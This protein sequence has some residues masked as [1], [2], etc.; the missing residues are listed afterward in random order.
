MITRALEGATPPTA[1]FIVHPYH[2]LAV[3]AILA[4]KGLNVPRDISLLCR[5]DD[6]CLRYLPVVPSRYVCSPR[7]VAEAVFSM[8][9]PAL[10]SGAIRDNVKSVLML[11][12]FVEGSSIAAPNAIRSK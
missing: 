8:L 6:T 9:I 12:D 11:P 7:K 1:L 3:A 4:A 2:Y 5:D 10:S